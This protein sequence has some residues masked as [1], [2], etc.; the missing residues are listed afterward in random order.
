MI[1][2][3]VK[4]TFPTWYFSIIIRTSGVTLSPSNPTIIIC[5]T[6]L[7][8][9][10]RR[11]SSHSNLGALKSRTYRNVSSS[12]CGVVLLRGCAYSPAGAWIGISSILDW[13]SSGGMLTVAIILTKSLLLIR[14]RAYYRWVGFVYRLRV[15]VLQGA[16]FDP[17]MLLEN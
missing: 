3:R 16:I 15:L 13:L 12:R 6:S 10:F 14:Y 9:I 7:R 17:H 5:P 1:F 4:I 11:F 2:R 8:K